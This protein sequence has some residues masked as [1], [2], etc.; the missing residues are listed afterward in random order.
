MP[1]AKLTLARLENLLLTGY[2]D[3]RGKVPLMVNAP[4]AETLGA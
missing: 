4:T 2:H 3:L 1:H